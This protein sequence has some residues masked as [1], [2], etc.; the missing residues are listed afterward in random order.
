VT[1]NL[2]KR[3]FPNASDEFYR[4]NSDDNCDAPGAEP[5]QAIRDEPL[6]ETPREANNSPRFVVSITSRRRRLLD[7]DNL[8]G[9]VKYFV[10]GLRYASLI[11]GDSP[12]C[13]E[14]YVRQI[15]VST[16]KE[17]RTEIEIDLI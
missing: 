15:K 2:L 14:L 16:R 5:E 9:G 6:A 11:P 17:E 8:V 7:P 3:I 12:D 10:D 13:I 4:K 1:L